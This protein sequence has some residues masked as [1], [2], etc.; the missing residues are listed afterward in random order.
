MKAS[1]LIRNRPYHGSADDI[2]SRAIWDLVSSVLEGYGC[3]S[4]RAHR[5]Y[6]GRNFTS[7]RRYESCLVIPR[8]PLLNVTEEN[9][10]NTLQRVDRDLALSVEYTSHPA[11]HHDTSSIYPPTRS[12]CP[13]WQSTPVIDQ[14]HS[15]V[16]E[17]DHDF[18]LSG[19]VYSL[20][21]IVLAALSVPLS[22]V[23]VFLT[24]VCFYTRPGALRVL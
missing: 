15:T 7:V 21:S 18:G 5:P 3:Q 16:S 20:Q 22:I 13:T 8:E 6:G 19:I 23:T 4:V 17:N 9:S 12:D 10:N 2:D 24:I 1:R 14:R 11:H